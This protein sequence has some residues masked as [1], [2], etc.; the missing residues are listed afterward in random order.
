[1][2]KSVEKNLFANSR[3]QSFQYAPVAL[4]YL[5]ATWLTNAHFMADTL[6][7][8]YSVVAHIEGRDYEF[9]EF[10]HLLWRPAVRLGYSVANPLF[11][12]LSGETDA[13]AV[14][15]YVQLALVWLSGLICVLCLHNLVRTLCRRGWIVYATTAA[16][17]L[18]HG[19]LNFAQTGSSYIPGLAFILAGFCIL[20]GDEDRPA[21]LWRRPLVAGLMLATGVCLWFLYIWA[22]PAALAAPVILFG[23]SRRRWSLIWRTALAL[24]LFVGVAYAL[25]L[26]HLGIYTPGGVKAWIAEASHGV[27]VGGVSRVVFGLARSFIYTGNDGL[28]FKRFLLGDALNPVSALDLFRLS[29]WKLAF[30]Y[31]FLATMV[32]NLLRSKQG[33]R[34]LGLFLLNAVPVIGFAIFFDGGAVERYLPLYPALFLSLSYSLCG[35]RS[36]TWL[37]IVALAFIVAASLT[38]AVAM[39][40]SSLDRRQELI[41]ARVRELLPLKPGSRV[42]GV[43]LQDEVAQFTQS[44][45]FHPIN[46]HGGF[47]LYPIVTIGTSQVAHWRE[48][49]ARETLAAWDG[50]GEMW[51]TRRVQSARPRAGWYWVEGDDARV[52]WTDLYGFFSRL[53][54]GL[55]VGGDD[56]FVL[57]ARSPENEK[58]LRELVQPERE[59]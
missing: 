12:R 36:W 46:R 50:G 19:F 54:T 27:E 10:G 32:L 11:F 53:E 13:R 20:I 23:A 45:P 6:D 3:R 34:V 55:A 52:S 37:K 42:A 24:G 43:N 9:W 26:A 5:L 31:L 15:L 58:I 4:A 49:F 57:L 21:S 8:T 25:T 14:V 38:N 35:E 59:P 29:L 40:A 30:F 44:F 48:D 17:I 2:N 41:S 28:W 51:V 16:F 22:L 33:V 39:S 47:R 56:G 18:S 1:M 7:Y